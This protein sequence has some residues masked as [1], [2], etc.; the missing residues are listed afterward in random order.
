MIF[1]W[2]S[3][4]YS[5]VLDIL[6]HP[7]VRE[8][9]V[10]LNVACAQGVG[11]LTVAGDAQAHIAILSPGGSVRGTSDPVSW[12][13][14]VFLIGL[15]GG[16]E[17]DNGDDFV[18]LD[19]IERGRG[20]GAVVV[21]E[22]A[23]LVKSEARRGV[24]R[25]WKRLNLNQLFQL[26]DLKGHILSAFEFLVKLLNAALILNGKA[27]SLC[28]KIL[29]VRVAFRGNVAGLLEEFPGP[30][31]PSAD[32]ADVSGIA[33]DK[34]LDWDAGVRSCSVFLD[35]DSRFKG[36]YGWEGPVGFTA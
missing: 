4:G 19:F 25:Y 3:Q 1:I 12:A 27:L 22:D 23:T 33:I 8:G 18:D 7:G 15:L 21:R 29:L 28:T 26:V 13:I 14:C 30:S 9:G 5:H 11:Q 6:Q 34:M 16:A 35:G 36:L 10:W 32:T 17:A 31:R 20:A 2:S 24:N